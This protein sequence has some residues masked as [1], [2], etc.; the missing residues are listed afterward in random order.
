MPAYLNCETR[1]QP[2]CFRVSFAHTTAHPVHVRPRSL[3]LP[4][5]LARVTSFIRSYSGAINRLIL[6]L[7]FLPSPYHWICHPHVCRSPIGAFG[8]S[9][10]DAV[11]SCADRN[12]RRCFCR[13]KCPKH[14]TG[15]ESI[16]GRVAR[17]LT[18]TH[19]REQQTRIRFWQHLALFMLA[20]ALV[21][22][23]KPDAIFHAQFWAED[24]R[25]WFADAYNLGPWHPFFRPETGYFQTLPRIAADLAMLVPLSLAPLVLNIIAIGVQVLPINLLVSFRSAE[26]GET[27]LRAL[28]AF[29]YL[30]IPSSPEICANITNEQWILAF[31]V[32]LLLVGSPPRSSSGRFVDLSFTVLCGL[33]GPFCIFLLPISLLVALR[34]T[35]RWRW[36]PV[37]ILAGCC[38]IQAVGLLIVSPNARTAWGVLGARFDLFVR[39]LAGNV[40]L[41]SLIGANNIAIDPG[42]HA[43]I[44]LAFVAASGVTIAAFALRRAP[45]PMKLLALY[46]GM[47][48]LAALRL[49]SS[50]AP[51]G[52][53]QWEMIAGAAAVRYWFLPTLTFI[54][55]LIF[56]AFGNGKIIKVLS[57]VLLCCL[58]FGIAI[59]WR[60]PVF[61]DFHYAAEVERVKAAPAGTTVSIPI[62]PEGWQMRLIK[63]QAPGKP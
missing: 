36:V 7:P 4:F 55:L 33:T 44:F 9:L 62:N 61:Q 58:C 20:Y 51:R 10:P 50:Y 6:F 34:R 24:G 53:T 27:W 21:I 39:I 11:R 1:K 19:L 26:W 57:G 59:Q 5:E 63:H 43:F 25:A 22:T 28:L 52:T 29:T 42:A 14:A 54:W 8:D 32:F 49:P 37:F 60:R 15:L 35:G 45:L 46:A 56:G 47:L 2:V 23:R 31:C 41:G 3:T 13:T 17:G 40:F 48:F 18:V 38:V 12:F 16:V 30:A